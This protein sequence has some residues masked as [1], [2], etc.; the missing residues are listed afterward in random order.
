MPVSVLLAVPGL[1]IPSPFP[2]SSSGGAAGTWKPVL[3]VS[4]PLFLTLAPATVSVPVCAADVD[5]A[6]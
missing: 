6:H 3:L 2:P 1:N 4:S 5:R